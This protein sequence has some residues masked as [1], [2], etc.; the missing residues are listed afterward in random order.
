M[1]IGLLLSTFGAGMLATIN[2]CGFALLPAYVAYFLNIGDP[3]VQKTEGDTIVATR[4]VSLVAKA[5]QVGGAT[6]V[7][8]IV[9]FV[10][11]IPWVSLG[12]GFVIIALTIGLAFFKGVLVKRLRKIIPYVERVSAVLLTGGLAC[13]YPGGRRVA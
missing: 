4:G 9:L 5:M 8:F 10:S 2:P 13:F 3:S 1:S 7:G 12:I 6:T 11:T